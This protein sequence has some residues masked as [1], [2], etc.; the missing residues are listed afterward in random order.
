MKLKRFF[1]AFIVCAVV[2]TAFA[3]TAPISAAEST[4]DTVA[5][6]DYGVNDA[7][8]IQKFAADLITL[9]ESEQNEYDFERDGRITVSDAS[10]LQKYLCGI[11]KELPLIPDENE[12]TVPSTDRNEESTTYVLV[13]NIC[14]LRFE[15]YS[16]DGRFQ[17]NNWML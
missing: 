14:Q 16:H 1:S 9:S 7:T 13:A 6:S 5:V 2:L 4:P 15:D 8:I 12:S 17:H 11:I 3:Y 10:V